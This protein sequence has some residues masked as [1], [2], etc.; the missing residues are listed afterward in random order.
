M[1]KVYQTDGSID[2]DRSVYEVF[3]A[4]NDEIIWATGRNYYH[5]GSQDGVMEENTTPR[6]LYKDGRM[7]VSLKSR[8]TVFH[9]GRTDH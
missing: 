1:Y 9:E 3:Q 2:A 6:D 5:T 8:S 7:F 4:Y